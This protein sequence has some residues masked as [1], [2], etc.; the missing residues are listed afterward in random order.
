MIYPTWG[1]LWD[2]YCTIR[3][4]PRVTDPSFSSAGQSFEVNSYY[5]DMAVKRYNYSPIL[6]EGKV[7]LIFLKSVLENPTNKTL[8]RKGRYLWCSNLQYEGVNSNGLREFSFTLD[9]GSK[10]FVVTENNALCLPSGCYVNNNK[11]FRPKNKTFLP[12]GSVF[13]YRS[14][15]EMFARRRQCSIEEMSDLVRK[16][17]PYRPG[18][19]VIPR[20]GYFYPVVELRE[21]HP[22]SRHNAHPC[23][24]VLGPALD[25][26]SD[27][28]REFYRVRFGETTYE[29]VHPVQM[30]IVNEV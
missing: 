17:S 6:D 8:V 26:N 9:T 28:G 18:T 29:R 20:L 4:R 23:G 22:G 14:C 10:R 7:R 25:N 11:F 1:D 12:F 13:N 19:L 24:L 27:G 5:E 30:E 2:N 15:L 16:D 21:N 3:S